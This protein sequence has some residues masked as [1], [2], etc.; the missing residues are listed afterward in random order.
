MSEGF[1]LT[2]LVC[3]SLL[4]DA[5]IPKDCMAVISNSVRIITNLSMISVVCVCAFFSFSPGF[6]GLHKCTILPLT[7]LAWDISNVLDIL[8]IRTEI[9]PFLS[10]TIPEIMEAYSVT[11]QGS[12][13]FPSWSPCKSTIAFLILLNLAFWNSLGIFTFEIKQS[14]R[15]WTNLWYFKAAVGDKKVPLTIQN[16]DIF[17]CKIGNGV[18]ATSVSAECL[19]CKK[20]LTQMGSEWGELDSLCKQSRNY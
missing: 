19:K 2:V 10:P 4:R 6:F 14:W 12:I 8:M 18:S 9:F 20:Q 7:L 3:Y 5:A 13:V 1:T 17:C 15:I 11:V 16:N